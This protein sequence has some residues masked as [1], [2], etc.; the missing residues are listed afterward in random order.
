MFS[1]IAKIGASFAAAALGTVSMIGDAG[2]VNLNTHGAAFQAFNAA[3]AIKI[4]YLSTGA[5]TISTTAQT[6]IA[7]VVRSPVTA[8]SQ[9]FFIDGSNSPG[10]T[11]FFTLSAFNFTGAFQSSVSF[12]SNAATYD[13]F[14]TLTTV[15]TFSYVELLATVP[16]NGG[17]VL[18][19]VTALQP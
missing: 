16:A 6:L 15:S 11:T 5:R 18:F 4:D 12:N 10:Q 1:K 13:L 19:G 9:S 3:E 14:Q 2:A 7:P 17:G 8:A